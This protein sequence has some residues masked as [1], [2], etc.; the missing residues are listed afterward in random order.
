MN[1]LPKKEKK[2]KKEKKIT[3]GN[4]PIIY[5]YQRKKAA[6]Q[7]SPK[8]NYLDQLRVL[9]ST[10]WHTDRSPLPLFHSNT[11]QSSTRPSALHK[12]KVC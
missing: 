12:L 5:M 6:Y 10:K 11:L 9:P 8:N 7:K 4:H 3:Q 2:K 1:S